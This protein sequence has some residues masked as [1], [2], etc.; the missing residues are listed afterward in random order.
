LVIWWHAC[1]VDAAKVIFNV[2]K[3]R[4]AFPLK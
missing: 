1:K 4:F 2:L 3:K